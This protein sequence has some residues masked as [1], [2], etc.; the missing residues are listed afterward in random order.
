MSIQLLSQQSVTRSNYSI[1]RLVTQ[2]LVLVLIGLIWLAWG[3]IAQAQ[4]PGTVKSH[5]KISDTGTG[6]IGYLDDQDVFGFDVADLGD[7]NGDG[8]S[9]LAAGARLDDDGGNRRGAVW[10][11]FMNPNGTIKSFQ[12]ISDTQGGFTGVLDNDDQ[13]GGGVAGI[14]DWDGDG[15]PDLAVGAY[16]D[17]DGGTD[18]GAVW[19]LFLNSNGTVKSHQKISATQGNFGGTLSKNETFGKSITVIGDIDNDTVPDLAVGAPFDDDT[20]TSAEPGA[21]WILFMNADGTVKGEQEISNTQ[22]GFTGVLNNGDF[23]GYDMVNLGDMD[24]DGVSDLAVGASRDDDGGDGRGAVWL[25]FMNS[26]GT[27]KGQ[28]KI[29]DTQGSFTGVLDDADQFGMSVTNLGDIDGDTIPDLAVGAPIDGD[30]GGI[31]TGAI[32]ILFMNANGTVK[33]HQKIS[34]IQGNFD[35]EIGGGLFAWGLSSM[36]DLDGDGVP[37]IAVGERNDDDGGPNRGSV[38]VLFLNVDGTVKS[39]QKIS[40]TQGSFFLDDHDQFGYAVADLGDVN[41]DGVSDLAVG[42][43][44][45]DDGG[46]G[47]GAVWILFMNADGTVKS[48]QK[49]SDTQGGFTGVLDNLDLFG[50]TVASLGDWDGDGVPDLAVGAHLDDDGGTDRGAVWLLFLNSNGTIKGHQKISATQGNFGG[51]LSRYDTFGKAITVIG[52]MDNDTVPELAVGAPYDDDTGTSGQP[53]AIWILFM[54]ADGTVKRQQEISD[55][56]GGFTGVLSNGDLF[57]FDISPLG[58]LDGDEVPDVVVGAPRDD[59]GGNARGAVWVLFLNS[60]G[61][62]KGHQKISDTQGDFTDVL[63]NDDHFGISV[64]NLGDIDG[65]TVPDLAVGAVVDDDGGAD[66]GA[67][68]ILFVNANGTV[69]AHQKISSTQGGFSG[70]VNTSGNFAWSVSSMGDLDGDGVTDIV[71]GE[72]AGDDGG[73]NRGAAWILFLNGTPDLSLTKSVDDNTPDSNQQIVYTLKVY[74]KGP[75]DAGNVVISDTLDSNLSFLGPVTLDPPQA[76]AIL[77]TTPLSLPTVA[78]NLTI[79]PG[80]EITLT[81]PVQ[82]NGGLPAGWVINNTAGAIGTGMADWTFDSVALTVTNTPT[83]TPTP[84]TPPAATPTPTPTNT[85]TSIPNEFTV[86]INKGA[87]YTKDDDVTLTLY[88]PDGITHVQISNDGGFIGANWEDYQETIEW[89]I[90]RFGNYVIPRIVY[91]RFTDPSG[92]IWGPYQDDIILDRIPPWGHGHFHH[93][94]DKRST[95]KLTAGDDVSGIDRMRLSE[96]QDFSGVDWVAYQTEVEWDF[97]QATVAYVQFRDKAGNM[98]QPIEISYSNIFLPLILK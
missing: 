27:V 48:H 76:G 80:Q 26:N 49:I 16:R 92:V 13:F 59:D 37:D 6:F 75:G 33:A 14:G 65:D 95:L 58:D 15:V 45:D 88:A 55:T 78:S 97:D 64:T 2:L 11:L 25:L 96:R 43:A 5:Q 71:V 89:E 51:T 12:K 10:I 62:V 44:I 63:D 69:K 22:G 23:F 61:T 46:D 38:W 52:D 94:T 9:D 41:D 29:S 34:A 85:A 87:L 98:S 31:Y 66:M 90:E 28:Q 3:P 86:T 72:R 8:V 57:G 54:N 93:H 47:R 91:V 83:S 32:W 50:S 40:D 30:G 1:R 84:V 68:W 21:I 19:L 20:G 42:A 18:R 82:V 67:V 4:G 79:K 81:F 56:Q 74:N 36:G 35:G 60:N 53:G 70:I 73:P 77:A 17:D 24:G 39:Y 7:V